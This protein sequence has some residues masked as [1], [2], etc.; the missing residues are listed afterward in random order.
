MKEHDLAISTLKEAVQREPESAHFRLW[1]VSALMEAKHLDDAETVAREVM[2]IEPGF[3]TR[4]WEEL[5]FKDADLNDR[6]SE[7]LRRAGLPG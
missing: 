7:N 6:I 2:R 4:I 1:L 5:C 3:S